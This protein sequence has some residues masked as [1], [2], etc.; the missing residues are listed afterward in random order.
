MTTR[1]YY[2]ASAGDRLAGAQQVLDTHITSSATGSCLACGLRGS[3]PDRE[4]AMVVFSRSLRL[5]HRHPGAT[6]PELVGL[7]RIDAHG[8]RGQG[9]EACRA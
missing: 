7:R 2:A 6:R 1:T 5:P 9:R 4:G 3:C 8:L